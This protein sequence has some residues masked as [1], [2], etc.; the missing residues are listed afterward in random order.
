MKSIKWTTTLLLLF[1]L[2]LLI[3]FFNQFSSDI[4]SI[5]NTIDTS[6]VFLATLSTL[7]YRLDLFKKKKL[8]L[9]VLA[10]FI[11]TQVILGFCLIEK[12]IIPIIWTYLVANFVIQCSLIIYYRIPKY[13]NISKSAKISTLL[14]SAFLSTV[15]IF[16]LNSEGLFIFGLALLSMTT[17]LI[18]SNLFVRKKS[19]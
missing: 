17:I 13:S 9:D 2:G 1:E 10:S 14:S 6:T 16:K 18:L 15:T 11:I 4:I 3:Y 19:N 5:N 8:K 7:L 12:S